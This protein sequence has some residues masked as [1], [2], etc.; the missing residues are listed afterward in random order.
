MYSRQ[1]ASKLRQEFWTKFG[2]FMAHHRS[3]EGRRVNWINYKTGVRQ[4]FFR[5]QA[6]SRKIYLGIEINH[7]DDG[8]RELFYEQFLELKTY[9]HSLLEEEWTW[10]PV[11]FNEL[12]QPIARIYTEQSGLN[13]FE[14]DQWPEIMQFFKPRLLTLDEF[15]VDAKHTFLALQN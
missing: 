5:S 7:A 15:W 6:D 10:E 4:V 8:I 2:R 12:D 9:L 1:E 3:A 13:V 11:Y 14:P